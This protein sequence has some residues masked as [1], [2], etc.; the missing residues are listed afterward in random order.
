MQE[1]K[2]S[3]IRR[4]RK[5]LRDDSFIGVLR[6]YANQFI[7]AAEKSKTYFCF[8][9]IDGAINILEVLKEVYDD[10]RK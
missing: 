4:S 2:W 3:E 7:D 5:D 8:D 6:F 9:I 10:R 1:H